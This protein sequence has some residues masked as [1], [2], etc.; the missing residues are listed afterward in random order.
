MKKIAVIAI[1]HQTEPNL[2]LHGLRTDNQKWACAGGHASPGETDHEAATR[3]LEEETGLKGIKLDKVHEKVYGE[4]HV[5]LFHAMHPANQELN[6][7]ADPD[8]EFVTFKFL[9]P[10]TH[11]NLHVPKNHN[12]IADWLKKPLKKDQPQ[13]KFPKVP[14][15]PTRLDQEVRSVP[16]GQ[17]ASAKRKRNIGIK[18]YLS[19][20]S[21]ATGIPTQPYHAEDTKTMVNKIGNSYQSRVKGAKSVTPGAVT[22][23]AFRHSEPMYGQQA[24]YYSSGISRH[25]SRSIHSRARSGPYAHESRGETVW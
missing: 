23:P 3:E 14:D 5:V 24:G 7:K 1:Q 21:H 15:I 25:T 19:R 13:I 22:V 9:D 10:T 4:N 17:T 11:E 16:P 18:S 6:A 8:K 12:I 20:L 2:F